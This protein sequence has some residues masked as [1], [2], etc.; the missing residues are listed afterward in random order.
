MWSK[1]ASFVRSEIAAAS[2]AST[3]ASSGR[4]NATGTSTIR[5]PLIEHTCRTVLRTA[6]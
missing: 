1:T 3:S 4:G 6:P 2:P 5:A